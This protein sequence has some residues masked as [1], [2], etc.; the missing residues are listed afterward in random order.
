M[1][2]CCA[3][4]TN[5]HIHYMSKDHL[6]LNLERTVKPQEYNSESLSDIT[7][8]NNKFFENNKIIISSKPKIN[9]IY[10]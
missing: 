6:E 5:S 3:T 2:S 7:Q 1:G 9:V 10:S 8:D 4:N